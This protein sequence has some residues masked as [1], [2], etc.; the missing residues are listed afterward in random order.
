[1]ADG[2]T[3]SELDIHGAAQIRRWI[4][5]PFGTSFKNNPRS[6]GGTHEHVGAL[7]IGA[8]GGGQATADA[9][10]AAGA[11]VLTSGCERDAIDPARVAALLDA[12]L[13]YQAAYPD[14]IAAR[15][16]LHRTETATADAR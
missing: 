10:T 11:R 12:A 7:V 15:I 8:G 14:E 16:E 3:R 1:M 5:A 9:L 4:R 6:A 13:R 2:A